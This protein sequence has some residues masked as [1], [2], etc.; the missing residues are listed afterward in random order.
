MNIGLIIPLY[1]Q[2][3]YWFNI[4]TAISKQTIT[5]DCVYVV[6]DRPE[7]DKGKVEGSGSVPDFNAIDYIN[8]TNA[9]F[10]DI[11]I[12]VLSFTVPTKTKRTDSPTFF[13]GYARNI[14]V[15]AAIED[16]CDLFVFIDGDCIPQR[17]LI[18]SHV[19]NCSNKLPVLSV[20]RRLESQYRWLDQR[21]VDS[22]LVHLN[23]FPPS[24]TL[25]NN[26]ELIRKCLVVWSCN[27]ALN[28]SAINRILKFNQIY[29]KKSELFS[30]EFDGEWGGEDSFLG[31]QA[32]Y[33]RLYINTTGLKNGGVTHTQHPRPK[34][35]HNINHK[36][37]FDKQ[38][39]LLRKKVA[40][41]P[42]KLSFFID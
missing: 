11:N 3:S 25:I 20:G 24:G 4:L 34:S 30:S 9:K 7:V 13:A 17:K 37:Y 6:L 8:E 12:K 32:W 10:P 41:T 5:P 36:D 28:R 42:L 23:L 26:V 2:S 22:N 27:I 40:I 38:V 16:G 39:E 14:G 29:Y 35:T 19:V 21:E 31:V 1:N 18:E 15:R 33:C